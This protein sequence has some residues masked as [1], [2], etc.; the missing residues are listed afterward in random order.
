MT[1]QIESF[2]QENSYKMQ[3]QTIKYYFPLLEE[4]I[5]QEENY[6]ISFIS[7]Y[8]NTRMSSIKIKS[9][10]IGETSLCFSSFKR[11]SS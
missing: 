2:A 11:K 3:S 8:F 6:K 9:N 1:E 5:L 4:N 10:L 7:H